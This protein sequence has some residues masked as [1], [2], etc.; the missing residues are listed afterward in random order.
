MSET[1]AATNN[2][3]PRQTAIGSAR[4]GTYDEQLHAA[5]LVGGA[6]A[7]EAAVTLMERHDPTSLQQARE[8]VGAEAELSPAAREVLG[9]AWD[10]YFHMKS[11]SWD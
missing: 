3:D 5:V 7:L 4:Q 6:D 1:E 8:L 2:G 10:R 11:M 9:E